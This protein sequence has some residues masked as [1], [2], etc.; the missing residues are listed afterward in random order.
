MS[1]HLPAVSAFRLRAPASTPP[2]TPGRRPKASS[3]ATKLRLAAVINSLLDRLERAFLAQRR[4]VADAAHELK[5]PLSILAGEAQEARRP[6]TTDD[7]RLLSLETI[8]R[9]ARGLARETDDLLWLAR[10]DVAANGAREAVDL[11]RLVRD[12][13]EAVRPVAASRSIRS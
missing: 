1:K 2:A 6:D 4:L 8:E 3:S 7:Q 10:G 5:T 13:A 11:A 12:T 9:T